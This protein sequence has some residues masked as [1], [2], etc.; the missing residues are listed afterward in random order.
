MKSFFFDA[1][2]FA[3]PHPGKNVMQEGLKGIL[4]GITN[5]NFPI[6]STFVLYIISIQ[7]LIEIL[8]SLAKCKFTAYTSVSYNQ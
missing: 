8:F 5:Q 6:Y 4:A 2:F 1:S 7:Y 3:P